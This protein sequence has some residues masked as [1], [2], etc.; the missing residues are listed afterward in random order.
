[1]AFRSRDRSSLVY[2]QNTTV[3]QYELRGAAVPCR[4]ELRPLIAFRDY[5]STTHENGALNPQIEN[6]AGNLKITPY[7]G[8]PSPY[9]AHAGEARA[10]GV[11]YR[12]F[13]YDRERERWLDYRE[14]LFNPCVLL[15]DFGRN[16][17]QAVI[18]STEPREL[19]TADALRA[20]EVGRRRALTS[21]QCQR[22]R[23]LPRA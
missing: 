1:M 5:H 2:E 18:A 22:T 11:W 17:A 23:R 20:S 4:L 6:E 14:D 15:A 13:E 10:T 16:R 8:L 19:A 9:L 3:I 7:P 12:D 21:T